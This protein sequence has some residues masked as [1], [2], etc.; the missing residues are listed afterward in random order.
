MFRRSGGNSGVVTVFEYGAHGLD[1]K[2]T[3][4]MMAFPIEQASDILLKLG[5]CTPAA[6]GELGLIAVLLGCGSAGN[7]RG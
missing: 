6:A 3:V 5:A 4:G 1:H 7:L 2:V